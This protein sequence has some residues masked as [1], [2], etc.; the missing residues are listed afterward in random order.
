[1]D[2]VRK[3]DK[4]LYLFGYGSLLFNYSGDAPYAD[5]YYY[6]SDTYYTK[7]D[8]SLA[9]GWQ[10]PYSEWTYFD[11]VGGAKARYTWV[12]AR[13]G[14]GVTWVDSSGCNYDNDG[15]SL[16]G[17]TGIRPIYDGYSLFYVFF[18]NGARSSGWY[19]GHY[20]SPDDGAMVTSAW[21]PVPKGKGVTWV[22]SYGD[23]VDDSNHSLED[24]T[25]TCTINGDKYLFIKGARQ[26][27]WVYVNES[28]VTPAKKALGKYYCDP[29]NDG[30]V[31][32]GYFS[33]GGKKY[34]AESY[35]VIFLPGNYVKEALGVK[36]VKYL[37]WQD[38]D[39]KDIIIGP[40]GA[41][42]EYAMVN[43]FDPNTE[44]YH[45]MYGGYKGAVMTD[46]TVEIKGNY[47]HFDSNGHL[48]KSAQST[49]YYVWTEG[50]PYAVQTKLIDVK[51]PAKGTCYFVPM[52]N[53]G[54]KL[55]SVVLTR[56]DGSDYYA[57]VVLNKNGKVV[58]SAIATA[59][60]YA[61]S[62]TTRAFA[63]DSDG[64]VLRAY[65]PGEY[66]A[67]RVGKN[68]YAV[69]STAISRPRPAC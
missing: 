37:L 52:L 16:E 31:H 43:V 45:Y 3:I 56:K 41:L 50:G 23:N 60:V 53:G 61:D 67:V 1:M 49:D 18:K 9:T 54:K 4:K 8:C 40:D 15:H 33:V 21:V 38:S 59:R 12:P 22:N 65:S 7:A 27:G 14:K 11:P 64:D 63:V 36:G 46:Y 2:G 48:D 55:T 62:K 42:V 6:G 20:F 39:S 57:A 26:T 47:Y 30:R 58:T 51:N 69:D 29:D 28:G 13:A 35:G 17:V 5:L 24:V 25:K 10:Q 68:R 32:T 19:D 44:T 66:L 34:W